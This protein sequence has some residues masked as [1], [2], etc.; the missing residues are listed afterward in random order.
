MDDQ[1]REKIIPIILSGGGGFR[2]WPLSTI[3]RPKQFH[4]LVDS[5]SLLVDTLRRVSAKSCF[6]DPII[7]GNHQHRFLIAEQLRAS[8]FDHARIVLEPV[9]RN[10]APAA[11]VA[12]LLALEKGGNP[13]ILLAPA[14]HIILDRAAFLAAVQ[15]AAETAVLGEGQMVLFGLTPDSPATGYG[16]IRKGEALP[17]HPGAS[18]VAAFVE[19]PD[20]ETAVRL[21]ADGLHFWNSGIFLMGARTLVAEMERHA[22]EV[23][24]AAR[25]AVAAASRG[26]DFLYLDADA[27]AEAPSISLDYAVM[28]KTRRA[29]MISASFGWTD[30]GSWKTL[31]DIAQKNSAGTA[32]FGDI[33]DLGASNCYLRSEGPTVAVAGIRDLIIV[34][35]PEAVLVVHHD[36]DQ[37][38]KKLVE[39]LRTPDRRP[40]V[41]GAPAIPGQ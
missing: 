25:A 10:T 22:P 40:A 5:D 13:L 14:D 23:L 19:K 2:L 37:D 9:G 26:P 18:A 17:G 38:V 1:A 24:A 4:A 21:L 27:F 15:A 35:T 3:D 31:W 20:R 33:V 41:T 30:V 32:R 11:A 7:I 16:Y 39:Q 28:E 12:A 36:A 8:G 29:A 6:A 34:A